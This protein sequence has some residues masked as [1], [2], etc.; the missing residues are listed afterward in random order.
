MKFEWDS[1][2][3]KANIRKHGVTFEQAS[4]VF[5]DLFAL[6]KFY[7]EHSLEEDRWVLLGKS[8]N[9]VILVVIHTFKDDD[10]IEYVRIISARKAT[11]S[12]QQT[13]QQ[14]CPK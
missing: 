9:K 2:K 1:E 11:R 10:G 12:E 13:Y 14:R 4:Y 7:D 6:N 5:S 8:L 3:E